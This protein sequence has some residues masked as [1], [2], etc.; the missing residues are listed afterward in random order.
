MTAAPLWVLLA[1]VIG[2]L[3]TAIV[4]RGRE[5]HRYGLVPLC[6]VA[7]LAMGE[8]FALLLVAPL[9]PVVMAVCA[10]VAIYAISTTCHALRDGA[11]AR[12][13][14]EVGIVTVVA[15]GAVMLLLRR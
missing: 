10:V 14:V 6:G 15:F 12:A 8:V 5:R 4:L 7:G 1:A 2:A 11:S 9:T 3:D 13:F